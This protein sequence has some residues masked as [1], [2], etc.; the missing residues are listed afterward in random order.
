MF[1]NKRY[2]TRG[3]ASEVPL[4]I[5]LLIWQMIDKLRDKRSKVDYLQ[6][7]KVKHSDRHII[8][9]QS[10]SEP[11]FKTTFEFHTASVGTEE[12]GQVYTVWVIDDG[13]QTL[14]LFPEERWKELVFW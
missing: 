5:Q 4:T 12:A 8:I 1:D 6:V 13:E 11:E 10:S 9:E 2:L 7:F 3:I 14:M